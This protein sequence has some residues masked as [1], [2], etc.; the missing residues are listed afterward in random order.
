M[1]QGLI[2]VCCC[3]WFNPTPQV[4]F[5]LPADHGLDLKHTWVGLV[6]QLFGF[7]QCLPLQLSAFK[8]Q[9]LRAPSPLLLPRLSTLSQQACGSSTAAAGGGDA[10][11]QQ[12]PPG[13]LQLRLVDLQE[14]TTSYTA[15]IKLVA[16]SSSGSTGTTTSSSSGGSSQAGIQCSGLTA[17]PRVMLAGALERATAKDPT[18]EV[19]LS[20]KQPAGV[21]PFKLRL[22]HP[23]QGSSAGEPAVT[24]HN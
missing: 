2:C 10:Q 11:Q 6:Q 22:L 4:S 24:Q 8:S 17:T 15:T 18:H 7:L 3:C 16:A 5:L 23:V 14:T 19:T 13:Q 9:P 1:S 20:L 21:P 12:Q